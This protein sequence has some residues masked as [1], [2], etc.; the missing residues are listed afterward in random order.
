M[1]NTTSV[2]GVD[3][4]SR[5]GLCGKLRAFVVRCGKLKVDMGATEW[6]AHSVR[7]FISGGLGKKMGLTVESFKRP[8]GER[9]YRLA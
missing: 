8:D 7:G 3:P 2:T 1:G 5:L 4:K 6:Q 9:A